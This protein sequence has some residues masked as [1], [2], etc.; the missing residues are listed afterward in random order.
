MTSIML[1]EDHAVVAEALVRLLQERGSHKVVAVADSAEAAQERLA[2]LEPDLLIVDVTLPK[3]NGIELVAKLHETH[4][5][6]RCLMLSGHSAAQY[7]NRSLAAGAR[8][9]LLKED[10]GGILEGVKQV[11]EGNIYIS[12]ALRDV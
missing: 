11:L 1:V 2:D 10:I 9:Y 8:G 5:Q 3:M 12:K 4:P 7:V 6:L